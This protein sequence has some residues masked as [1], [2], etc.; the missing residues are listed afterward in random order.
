MTFYT[1]EK[2]GEI[3]YVGIVGMGLTV[4]EEGTTILYVDDNFS[5]KRGFGKRVNSEIW[6]CMKGV[7]GQMVKE[8]RPRYRSGGTE[9]LN[10]MTVFF[11]IRDEANNMLGFLRKEC[12]EDMY[13]A[14]VR[15]CETTVGRFSERIESGSIET[16]KRGSSGASTRAVRDYTT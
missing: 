10:E 16:Q 8:M 2:N 11:R 13:V 15:V 12:R 1:S 6:Q 4:E 14:G 5:A 7:L 3:T 9:S